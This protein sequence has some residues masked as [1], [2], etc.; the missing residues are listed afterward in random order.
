MDFETV[1]FDGEIIYLM[2]GEKVY[3]DAGKGMDADAENVNG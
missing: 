1:D 2:V 3:Q